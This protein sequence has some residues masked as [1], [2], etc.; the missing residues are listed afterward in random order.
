[1]LLFLKIL[2]LIFITST[3]A[4]GRRDMQMKMI[5]EGTNYETPYYV[6]KGDSSGPVIL[7]EA[8]IHGDEIAGVHALS[9]ILNKI[10]VSS[11]KLIIFPCMNIPAYN[12]G[13]RFINKD[14]NSVFPGIKG[15]QLYEFDLAREIYNMVSDEGIQYLLTLHESRYLHNPT[16]PRTF[17]QTIVYGV[18]PMPTYLTTWLNL[19]NQLIDSEEQIFH[20]YYFPVENSST[21][22]MVEAYGLKGGFCIETWRGFELERRIEL[23]TKVILTFMDTIDFKYSLINT[24]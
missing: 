23:Q 7:I 3:H 13:K 15:E 18:K 17:G 19:V 22:T 10:S 9:R 2:F 1:M 12:A 11:G 14:L 21:E 4:D 6:F 5:G 24:E 8:G 20:P 16:K